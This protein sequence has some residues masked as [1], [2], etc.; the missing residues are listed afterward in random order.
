MTFRTSIDID[1]PIEQVW[2][3]L[4]DVERWPEWSPTMTTVQ[5][6]EGGIFRPG[7]TARIK[8]PRLPEAV[9]RVSAMVPQ[10]S[11]T[12]SAH[13][14]GVTAVARHVVAAREEGGTRAASELDWHGP[15]ALLTRIFFSRL[16][17]RY[18][19]QESDGLKERCEAG[20]EQP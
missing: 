5:R 13:A 11:F 8:Q 15:L 3:V 19:K 17:K 20:R 12:W 9:W 4:V 18:L 1:A 14:R 16:T 6:L 7:S 2:D 10:K